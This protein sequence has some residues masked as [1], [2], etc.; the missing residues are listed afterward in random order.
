MQ[1]ELKIPSRTDC[2]QLI[3]NFVATVADKAGLEPELVDQV[4]LAVDEACSNVMLHAHG[5][6]STKQISVVVELGSEQL[7]IGI[8]DEGK[9]FDPTSVPSPDL[10]AHL[11]RHQ[12]GGLGIYLI[13]RLMDEVEYRRDAAGRNELRMTK[14]LRTPEEGGDRP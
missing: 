8:L 2:L 6:D 12:S 3:R 5:R 1:F 14:Y 10:D 4:E 7:V 9:P 11:A 13:R